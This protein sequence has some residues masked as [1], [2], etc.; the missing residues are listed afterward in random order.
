MCSSCKSK[1]R[2]KQTADDD[3]YRLHA[4]EIRAHSRHLRSMHLPANRQKHGPLASFRPRRR[5]H[6]H[7]QAKTYGSLA[8]CPF[9][10]NTRQYRVSARCIFA[11]RLGL[12]VQGTRNQ[13]TIFPNRAVTT[14]RSCLMRC[15]GAT[16]RLWHTVYP[17]T[18]R[19]VSETKTQ[20]AILNPG[21]SKI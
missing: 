7:L 15:S 20:L 4:L 2:P 5:H 16:S 12:L 14:I 17:V 6:H 13:S 18:T 10:L 9:R 1:T 11:V 21:Y 19:H 3:E 8:L